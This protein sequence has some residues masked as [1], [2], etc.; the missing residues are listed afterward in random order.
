MNE[1][2]L[3][4]EDLAPLRNRLKRAKGQI[5]GIIK[6]IDDDRDCGDVLTQ[7]AAVSKALDRTG[8]A[9]VAAGLQRC[10]ALDESDTETRDRLEKMFL[11]M[12]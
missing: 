9:L 2:H 1:V 12:A 3:S 7:L 6:M 11:A 10:Q 8:F 5:D 4:S